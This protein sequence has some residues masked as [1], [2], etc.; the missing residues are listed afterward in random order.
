MANK[1]RGMAI[2]CLIAVIVSCFTGCKAG[3]ESTPKDTKGKFVIKIGCDNYPPY[4]YEDMNG[5]FAG[6]DVDIATEA[7]ER[8]GYQ[9]QFSYVNWEQKKQLLEN[10]KIDCIWSCFSIDGREDQYQW[11]TPY[12]V[13]RQVVAVKPDSTIYKLAD[14]KDKRIVVQSST[15][16][17][18]IFSSHTDSRIPQI[19]ELFTVQNRELLYPFLS[20][21]YADAMAAHETAI[22]QYMKDYDLE[23]RILEEPLQVVGLGA[24]FAKNDDRGLSN[25]ISKQLAAMKKD[26]TLSKIIGKYLDD[27]DKYLEVDAD[28]K[29]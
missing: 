28:E 21:G 13:S 11:T 23:Y 19:K 25:E 20:K 6:L 10:G 29:E 17:D 4:S 27:P 3:Q 18:E 16:P 24:A 15:K 2:I 14:L 1:V 7:F 8:I 26:G 9:V 5:N 22:L 12:M